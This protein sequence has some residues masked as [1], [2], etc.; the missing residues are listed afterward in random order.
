MKNKNKLKKIKS[1]KNKKI[2]VMNEWFY[3]N[4][5]DIAIRELYEAILRM[6]ITEPEIWE[7][8]QIMEI[9]LSMQESIDVEKLESRFGDEFSDEFMDKRNIRSVFSFS[10]KE[11]VNESAMNIMKELIKELGGIFCADTED[12]MPI[13][14]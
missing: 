6:N 4:D 1:E 11:E 13:I 7:E 9:P 3:M 10:F 12:F 2:V 14:E 8:Q 5:N